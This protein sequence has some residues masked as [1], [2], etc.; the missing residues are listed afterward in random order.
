MN[1]RAKSTWLAAGV[2][3][4]LIVGVALLLTFTGGGDAAKFTTH[5]VWSQSMSNMQSLK[6][7]DLTGD[8]QNDLFL[9][10]ERSFKIVDAG[11]QELQAHS[12]GTPLATTMGD[13]NGDGVED[14]AVFAPDSGDPG[15]IVFSQNE[16]LWRHPIEQVGSPAR[17]AVIRF[18]E[19]TLVIAGDEGGKLVAL[20]ATGQEVWRAE[21]SRGD[22]IRGLDDPRIDGQIHLAAANHDGHVALYDV[23]GETLWTYSTGVLRRLRAYDLDGDGNSEIL[24]GT[25]NG[26]LIMLA[27]ATGKELFKQRLGQ[28]VTEIREVEVDG[29]PSAREFVVGGKEG[30]VWAFTSSGTELWS[31]NVADKVNEIAAWD[32]DQDGAAE[33]IIGDDSGSVVVFA[34]KTGARF[35][36][37]GHS[38][39]ILRID[40]EKLGDGRRAV[41][42]DSRAVQVLSIEKETAPFFYSPLIVGLILSAVI[43]VAAWF[44]ASIPEKPAERIAIEDQSTEGLL[45]QR[46][47]LHENIADVERMK[48]AG[49]MP[50]E[51]YLARLKELRAELADNEASLKK[52]GVKIEAETMK[53]PNCAGTLPLGVDRC[54]YCGQIVIT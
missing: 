11:G 16:Q 2:L 15:V 3:V 37:S 44:V 48:Q 5:E 12:F 43:L 18:P 27:A 45:A 53:C 6:I 13:V 36:L 9:Q 41:I 39:A 33:T 23:T 35:D 22:A 10:N 46:R 31:S 26:Q 4:A 25:D 30:G 42:A 50:P 21:L 7:I 51:V 20:D 38:S 34:G 40:A 32:I 14:V 52:A 54:D 8:G 28:A 1:P 49:E 24:L 47:M 17:A 29:N 19:Q